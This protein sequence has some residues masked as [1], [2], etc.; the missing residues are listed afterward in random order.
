MRSTRMYGWMGVGQPYAF[1]VMGMAD[2]RVV[3][4]WLPDQNSDSPRGYRSTAM[5]VVMLRAIMEG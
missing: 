2:V 4:I 3:D 5:S 1:V